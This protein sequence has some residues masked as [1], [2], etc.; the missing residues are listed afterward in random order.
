MVGLI[1]RWWHLPHGHIQHCY[2]A[3][4][5]SFLLQ[6]GTG[7][8]KDG[9]AAA[10]LHTGRALVSGRF[11]VRDCQIMIKPCYIEL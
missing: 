11:N 5:P 9:V 6:E 4:V 3:T 10:A 8:I 7:S 2:V 1:R